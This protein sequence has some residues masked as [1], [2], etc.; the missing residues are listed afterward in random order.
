LQQEKDEITQKA[1]KKTG[2]MPD[3]LIMD[4]EAGEEGHKIRNLT[5]SQEVL[6]GSESWTIM[7]IMMRGFKK[8]LN[9]MEDS[10][11]HISEDD[12][13]TKNVYYLYPK[14]K[15]DFNLSK[16]IDHAPKV[17]F[18]IRKADG[19]TN[20]SFLKSIGPESVTSEILKGRLRTMTKMGSSGKSGSFFFYTNDKNYLIKTIKSWEFIVFCKM[21]PAYYKHLKNH[22]ET[23]VCRIY[24]LHKIQNLAMGTCTKYKEYSEVCVV[25]MK[26]IFNTDRE[27][28]ITY[29]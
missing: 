10:E 12:F 13:I 4:T 18:K 11:T 9:L 26:N 24:G 28:G 25:V 17:F 22:P 8:S 29:D 7:N 14:N 15:K 3:S 19:I 5:Q 16:F 2:Q 27:I 1:G 20:E 6:F 21:L 23:L